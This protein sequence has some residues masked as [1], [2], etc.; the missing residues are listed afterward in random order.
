MRIVRIASAVLMLGLCAACQPK[1]RVAGATVAVVSPFK[2]TASV[3]EIMQSMIDP[4]ADAVWDSVGTTINA[5]GTQHRQP[6]T[7][8]QWLQVRHEAIT[9]IESTNLLIMDGRRLVA[10]GAKMADEG[11]EGVLSAAQAQQRL[12]S[13]HVQF[14]QF[15]YALHDVGEQMLAAIDARDTQAMIAAGGTMDDVCEACHTTFWYAN[16]LKR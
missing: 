11:A 13:Q 12:D 3:Q 15:A 1:P 14:V 7:D 5:Q 8:A 4:S 6:R 2:L 9:L 16:Q 10:P